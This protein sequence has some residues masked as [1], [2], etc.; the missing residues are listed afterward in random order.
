MLSRLVKLVICPGKEE[1]FLA[2]FEK[3]KEKIRTAEGCME[4]ILYRDQKFNN[5]FFTFSIWRDPV[6]LENY[7]QSDLF[8]STWKKTKRL[9]ADKPEAWSV[10][11]VDRVAPSS[12]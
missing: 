3:S 7:R 5:I 6:D 9:F 10:N 11:Q 8:R 4:L 1:E 12:T 2:V